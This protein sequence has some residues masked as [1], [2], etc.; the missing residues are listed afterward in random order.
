MQ[1]VGLS[2]R[3][4]I[5]NFGYFLYY[6]ISSLVFKR[7]RITVNQELNRHGKLIVSMTTKPDR[8]H[9]TWMVIESVLR[10]D[11]K[12]DGI[13]LYLPCE[14]FK[15]ESVLP[16]KLIALK[17]RGLQIVFVVENLKPHN[18]YFYAMSAFPN[19]NVLTI[20]D[21]KIYPSNLVSTLKLYAEQHEGEICSV[22]TRQ[23]VMTGCSAEKYLNWHL[24]K[25][26]VGPSHDLLSL[27]VGG[28]LYPAGAL[29]KDVFDKEQLK[30]KALLTDD[31][32]IKIMALR[33]NTPVT[34]LA[35]LFKQPFLSLTGMGKD[36]LMLKNI[37]GGGND[38]VFKDLLCSYNI[39]I[40][41]IMIKSA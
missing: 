8:V 32:W 20:D 14:E 40:E 25:T 35:G 37:H 17:K 33:N 5:R 21:D 31:L 41:K 3:L 34:S 29:H 2:I 18:K 13:F 30:S 38:V 12:P 7:H 27:G 10:Q 11:L 9:K 6:S 39:D 16:Q 1:R 4:R 36:Q 28:V 23:I 26:N 19:A 22:L 15:D 24:M